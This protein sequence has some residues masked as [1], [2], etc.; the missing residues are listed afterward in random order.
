MCPCFSSELP[1]EL[2]SSHAAFICSNS[3]PISSF[4]KYKEKTTPL[5][6]FVTEIHLYLSIILYNPI[7]I[8]FK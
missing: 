8:S 2:S 5:L 7:F 4:L 6:F 1:K 3:Q